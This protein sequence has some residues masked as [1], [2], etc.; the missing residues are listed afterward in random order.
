[1]LAVVERVETA[2]RCPACGQV[3][4]ERVTVYDAETD[5]LLSPSGRLTGARI[6]GYLRPRML[7]A[8]QEH[9]RG[10]VWYSDLACA[11]WPGAVYDATYDR[12]IGWHAR[13]LDKE[14]QAAGWPAGTVTIARGRGVRFNV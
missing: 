3:V 1:M 11:M 9:G 13:E 14:L 10:L 2:C 7:L 12:V 4:R 8:L 6:G 5:T